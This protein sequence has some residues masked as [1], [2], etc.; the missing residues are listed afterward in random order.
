MATIKYGE[1]LEKANEAAR[2]GARAVPVLNPSNTEGRW[3][4]SN[5]ARL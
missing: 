5:M 4:Q 1:A 3:Q 2:A